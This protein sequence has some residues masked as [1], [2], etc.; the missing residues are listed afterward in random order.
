MSSFVAAATGSAILG[1]AAAGALIGG[2]IAAVTGGSVLDGALHGAVSGAITGGIGQGLSALSAAAPTIDSAASYTIADNGAVLDSAGNTVMGAGTF[3]A[4]SG[5]A[6]TLPGSDL[7]QLA[8]GN[9]I[10]ALQAGAS[11]SSLGLSQAAQNAISKSGGQLIS[12]LISGASSAYQAQQTS[13]GYGT[14]AAA[15]TNA[16]NINANAATTAGQIQTNAANTATGQAVAGEQAALGT[17][18]NTLASQTALYA[19]GVTAADTALANLTNGLST[20]FSM[21]NAQNMDA[22]KFAAQAGFNA[23]GPS[24]GTLNSN[25]VNSQMGIASQFEQQAFNQYT[26]NLAN[27]ESALTST[28]P[29]VNATGA[30]QSTAG[31]NTAT[32]Q[33]AIGSTQAS[34]TTAAADAQAN[35]VTGAAGATAQGILGAGGASGM[36]QIQA[37]NIISSGVNT[38]GNQL[39]KLGS[40]T[41]PMST[42]VNTP[43]PQSSANNGGLTNNTTASGGSVGSGYYGGSQSPTYTPSSTP[44]GMAT[45]GSNGQVL[46]DATGAPVMTGMGY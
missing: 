22:Y 46:T 3:G 6:V 44:V 26:Q 39:A 5:G 36:G 40:N 23:M 4:G 7:Q 20:P 35:A 9:V 33:R 45:Y 17:V 34:G 43:A 30:A 8:N 38:V 21:A 14:L 13:Q 2:G 18:G 1:G 29:Y 24:G 42:T 27:Q 41:T 12:S 15:N 11:G 31:A 37:G 32:L 28:T 19:P 25:E 16:A 10:T